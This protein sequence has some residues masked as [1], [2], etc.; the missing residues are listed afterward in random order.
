MRNLW[1]SGDLT[2]NK[3]KTTHDNQSVNRSINQVFCCTSNEDH[4]SRTEGTVK[5]HTIN[6]NQAFK[7]M[8]RA[9]IEKK[10][11]PKS[12]NAAQVFFGNE[13]KLEFYGSF[14][15][16][17]IGFWK[18]RVS[19]GIRGHLLALNVR[20]FQGRCQLPLNVGGIFNAML[21]LLQLTFSDGW[22]RLQFVLFF[23]ELFLMSTSTYYNSEKQK[24]EIN[25]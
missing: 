9:K 14:G 22:W 13:V 18:K 10:D 20:N 11:Y 3:Q 6:N 2:G 1:A 24:S 4:Y 5:R 19:V 25:Q 15:L 7:L 23:C 21:K 16:T 12:M 8:E 17:V